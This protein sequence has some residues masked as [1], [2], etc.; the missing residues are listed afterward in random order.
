MTVRSLLRALVGVAL[1]AW[2]PGCIITVGPSR[3]PYDTCNRGTDSCIGIS[4]C[5][6]ANTTTDPNPNAVAGTFCTVAS[7]RLSTDCPSDSAGYQVTCV[8]IGSAAYG[9]CYRVCGAGNTCPGG[10][11][12]G[13]SGPTPFCVP[14]GLSAACGTSGQAC[15]SG[16]ICNG[17]LVCGAGNTCVSGASCGASGQACCPGSSCN[18]GLAC[19]A[20][21]V[22]GVPCGGAGHSGWAGSS[23]TSGLTCGL[24]N[25]CGALCGGVGNPCCSGNVCTAAGAACGS[26]GLCGLAPY[27][28]CSAGSIGA[29]CLGGQNTGGAVIATTCQRPMIGNPG[30][31]GFCTAACSGSM[32]QCPQWVGAGRSYTY[33]CYLLQGGVNGQC[34]VDCPTGTETCPANT[35]CLMTPVMG[36]SPVR[37]C[38]PPSA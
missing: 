12:C 27:S 3:N 4:T 34:Y 15:C 31:D 16:N 9:Q 6:P 7:C 18:S 11:T 22:C 5:E 24:G 1:I 33:N 29:S 23:C 20:G 19:G 28:G 21:N 38:M 37:L 13:G 32:T 17:G 36:G 2:L 35:V 30:A 25:V 14:N 8:S 10:F 26:D